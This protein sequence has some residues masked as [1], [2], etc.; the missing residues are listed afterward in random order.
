MDNL[1]II[2]YVNLHVF[3]H[4]LNLSVSILYVN[5]Q[6]FYLVLLIVINNSSLLMND[7]AILLVTALWPHDISPEGKIYNVLINL[8]IC[9]AVSFYTCTMIKLTY[10]N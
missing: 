2:C 4:L 9:A 5:L 10:Y 7:V 1:S 3:L 6:L 8:M